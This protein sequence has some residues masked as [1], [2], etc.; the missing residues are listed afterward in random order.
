M[1]VVSEIFQRILT[2]L[3]GSQEKA[4]GQ[5]AESKDRRCYLLYEDETPMGVLV[6][7]TVVTNN[8]KS[9]GWRTVSSKVP[10]VDNSGVNSGKGMGSDLVNKLKEE[11][12][13]LRVNHKGI[14]VTVSETKTDS[15]LF[16]KKKNFSIVHEWKD[17][18]I[19]GTK[20]YLL[21]CPRYIAATNA[22]SANTPLQ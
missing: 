19:P 4:I 20:E 21:S 12:E 3:Y 18:Y 7:G 5:I 22:E 9:S 15:L 10:F 16:F 13:A 11:A 1:A 6:F 14:H 17:R 8:L 2:P